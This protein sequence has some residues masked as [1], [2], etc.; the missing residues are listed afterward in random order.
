V[1]ALTFA[2]F[3][4]EELSI[5]DEF[6]R[7][8]VKPAPGFVTDFHG[9]RTRTSSLW[10]NA[11][12]LD[13]K[14]LPKPV[15]G[16]YHG[17]VIEW[18]GLFK[19]V[20]AANGQFVAMELGAAYAPWL[21]AGAVAA[22]SKGVTNIRLTGIEGDPRRYAMMW[23]HF[24]D[25]G[26]DPHQHTLLQAGVGVTDGKAKWPRYSDSRNDAGFPV[27]S[28]AVAQV[29]HL[30]G[31][32]GDMIDVDIIS[33]QKLLRKEPLW[34]LVHIDVQGTEAELCA[35]SLDLL[36][37]TARYIIVGTHSRALDAQLLELLF[38]AGFVLEN[39][40]PCRFAFDPSKLALRWMTY[41][42][43]SQVWRNP[44]L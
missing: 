26:L 38:G 5:F 30:P 19:S 44:A 20:K 41:C 16:D 22:Q 40:R 37:A 33:I 31:F 29:N 4:R 1:R 39:E 9:S 3:N 7:V 10:D 27:S 32:D 8:D 6:G 23:Q 2:G 13:G 11:Q 17:D 36:K 25:N 15:S 34:D 21:V 12:H 14:L 18:L 43:G 42:D 35:A 28:E 24:L